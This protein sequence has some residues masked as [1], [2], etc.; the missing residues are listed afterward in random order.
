MA[1]RKRV[2]PIDQT[3]Q[4][5]DASIATWERDGTSDFKLMDGVLVEVPAPRTST[6][7]PAKPKRRAKRPAARTRRPTR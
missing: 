2:P 6:T 1:K 3:E 7:P 5:D 4:A